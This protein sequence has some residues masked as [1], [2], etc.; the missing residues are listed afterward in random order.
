MAEAEHLLALDKRLLDMLFT[1]V[2]LVVLIDNSNPYQLG[3]NLRY[4][5]R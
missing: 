2:Q 1:T 3:H 5:N 4:F